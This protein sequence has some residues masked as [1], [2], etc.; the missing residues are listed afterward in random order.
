MQTWHTREVPMAKL[1]VNLICFFWFNTYML[2]PIW[3]TASQDVFILV[4]HA[5]GA[6]LRSSVFHVVHLGS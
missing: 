2:K 3:N 1:R 5:M 6:C 4:G